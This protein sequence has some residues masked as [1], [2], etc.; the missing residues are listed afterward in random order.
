MRESQIYINIYYLPLLFYITEYTY[1]C[2]NIYIYTQVYVYYRKIYI[3]QCMTIFIRTEV[4]T[5]S[6]A[7][8]KIP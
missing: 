1:V 7:M 6:H 2:R 3:I 5:L 8:K 4:G